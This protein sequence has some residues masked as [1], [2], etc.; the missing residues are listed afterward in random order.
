MDALKRLREDVF[1]DVDGDFT[2]ALVEHRYSILEI[3][4]PVGLKDPARIRVDAKRKGFIE[5][6]LTVDGRERVSKKEFV[7]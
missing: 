1:F 5:R 2:E 6:K 7:V 4:V 3:V